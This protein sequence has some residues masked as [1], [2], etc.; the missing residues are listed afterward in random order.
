MAASLLSLGAS[1][2]SR[3]PGDKTRKETY[4]GFGPKDGDS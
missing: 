3:T 2:A 4:R 1:D